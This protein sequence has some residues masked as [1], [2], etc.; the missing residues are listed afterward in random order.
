MSY[1]DSNDDNKKWYEKIRLRR[2]GVYIN[3]SK[4]PEYVDQWRTIV[5]KFS[6]KI[7]AQDETE[8]LM[9]CLIE[10]V[11]EFISEDGS[12]LKEYLKD[13]DDKEKLWWK[14]ELAALKEIEMEQYELKQL[15]TMDRVYRRRGREGFEEWCTELKYNPD[16]YYL[17]RERKMEGMPWNKRVRVWLEKTLLSE[18][19]PIPILAIKTWAKEAGLLDDKETNWDAFYQIAKRMGVNNKPSKGYFFMGSIAGVFSHNGADT[20]DRS[21]E[22]DNEDLRDLF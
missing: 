2:M 4:H 8:F 14:R 13:A 9:A 7:R 12:E 5:A 10:K 18:I 15:E 21:D 17:A 11:N 1:S 20:G 16:D 22:I 6:T 3:L 19:H